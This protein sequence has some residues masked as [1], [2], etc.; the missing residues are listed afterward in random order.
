MKPVTNF[1]FHCGQ[2]ALFDRGHGSVSAEA[3]LMTTWFTSSFHQSD[4][5]G[6]ARVGE[7]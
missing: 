6:K 7:I 2:F 4:Q 5:T 1:V 3:P